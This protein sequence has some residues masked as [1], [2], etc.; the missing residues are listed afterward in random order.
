MI[1]VAAWLGDEVDATG[2]AEGAPL[3]GGFGRFDFGGSGTEGAGSA[4]A[5][6]SAMALRRVLSTAVTDARLDEGGAAVGIALTRLLDFDFDFGADA[7]V[8]GSGS[9]DSALGTEDVDGFVGRALK[10][11]RAGLTGSTTSSSMSVDE[12]D[13]RLHCAID[14]L[15]TRLSG[16]GSMSSKSSDG[17]EFTGLVE[18]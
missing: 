17:S 3:G 1:S 4:W 13:S 7:E 10:V 2:G 18:P 15:G 5:R 16:G 12:A 14:L 11:R 6:F 8:D 9:S